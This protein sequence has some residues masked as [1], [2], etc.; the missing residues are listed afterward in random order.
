MHRSN[1][2]P[3]TVNGTTGP[4]WYAA[5]FSII[6]LQKSKRYIF[7]LVI[8]STAIWCCVYLR[9]S[10]IKF[11]MNARNSQTIDDRFFRWNFFDLKQNLLQ[12]FFPKH[13]WSFLSGSLNKCWNLCVATRLSSFL[14]P[15]PSSPR[16][17]EDYQWRKR[18]LAIPTTQVAWVWSSLQGTLT[19]IL[20]GEV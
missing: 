12:V 19:L 18:S 1:G 10:L 15:W 9:W 5:A 20:K 8:N 7:L 14:T 3:S 11:K 17:H 13:L 6:S 2:A 4:G 16:G